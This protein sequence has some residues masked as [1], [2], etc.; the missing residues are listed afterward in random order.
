MKRTLSLISTQRFAIWRAVVFFSLALL[1][2]GC[3]KDRLIGSEVQPEGYLDSLILVD[4]FTIQARTIEN[5]PQRSTRFQNF[6]GRMQN[7]V[8]GSSEAELYL[9][10]ALQT[11]NI[12]LEQSPSAYDLIDLTLTILPLSGYGDMQDSLNLSVYVIEDIMNIDSAYTSDRKF[13][14]DDHPVGSTRIAYTS[15]EAIT[16][17]YALT[18][19]NGNPSYEGIKIPLSL[20]LASY[21]LQGIGTTYSTTTGF[22]EFFGGLAIVGSYDDPSTDGAIFNFDVTSATAG[23]TMTYALAE[24]GSTDTVTFDYNVISSSTRFNSFEIDYAGS[25][26]ESAIQQGTAAENLFVQGLSGVKSVIEIPYIDEFA[27]TT[28]AA[29]SLAKLTFSISDLQ[30]DGLDPSPSLFL[31]DYEIDTDGDTVETLTRDYASNTVRHGGFLDEENGT[32]T[33]DVTREVQ[34]IIEQ[35]Q[36]GNNVNLGFTLNAQVPVLN[37]NVRYQNV[38]KGSDN[39]VFEVYYTDISE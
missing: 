17:L 2:F 4:T 19:T 15:N 16:D 22:R 37:G 34:H 35:K 30:P 13:R 26:V 25:M 5:N 32:Y 1:V 12:Q 10:F 28:D 38:L 8:F 21:L 3:R 36:R 20:D 9:N 33:F 23:L 29:V 24:N 18:D 27:A 11:E 14:L 6:V 31:L 39:I 7:P